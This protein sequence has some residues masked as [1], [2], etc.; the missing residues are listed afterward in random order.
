MIY[1]EAVC[2]TIPMM[3]LLQA[4]NNGYILWSQNFMIILSD[5]YRMQGT[6]S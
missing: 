6:Y 1:D 5:A 2:I 3:L 4:D